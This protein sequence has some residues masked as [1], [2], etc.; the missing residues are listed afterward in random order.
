MRRGIEPKRGLAMASKSI[1]TRAPGA[2]PARL[3]AKIYAGGAAH[4]RALARPMIGA[5]M[6]GD[7]AIATHSTASRS[8]LERRA[9]QYAAA[10]AAAD[11]AI[12]FDVSHMLA[13]FSPQ[14]GK[15]SFRDP[16]NRMTLA[17][18]SIPAH[19]LAFDPDGAPLALPAPQDN[20]APTPAPRCRDTP[21]MI[22][23]P[24][25]LPAPAPAAQTKAKK[26]TKK[27]SAKP[28]GKMVYILGR[29]GC[30]PCF[31]SPG[32]AR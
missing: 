10:M 15:V 13:S 19:V 31:I 6:A 20:D 1:A 28:R 4:R 8:L 32:I 18:F 16:V 9:C 11:G 29:R 21:D 7:P 14:S 2:L 5:Q 27:R 12:P 30:S 17:S 22:A 25:A 3:V 24:P 23:A 26:K